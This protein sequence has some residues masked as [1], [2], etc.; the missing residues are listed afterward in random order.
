M[1]V[2]VTGAAGF[3]G[4]PLVE[5]LLS[6]GHKV[7]A[8]AR[9]PVTRKFA[10]YANLRWIKKDLA[11]DELTA[12]ELSDVETIF[13]LAGTKE[14]GESQ[15]ETV[16]LRANEE[17]TLKI[18]LASAKSV[19]KIIFASTQMVYG[20]PGNLSVA[21]DFPLLGMESSAYGCS[22][23]NAE[24]W[25]RCLQKQHGGFFISLRFCGFVEGGGNIDYIID[26]ALRNEPV[27]LLSKGEVCRDYLSLENGVDAF[28]A[29]S[30][31]VSKNGFEVF[32]IGS[33]QIISTHEMTRFICAELESK[34]EIILLDRKAPRDNF[35]FNIHK[36]RQFLKFEPHSLRKSICSYAHHKKS[37]FKLGITDA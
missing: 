6:Q 3:L 20:D 25:L 23:V 14:L 33:G 28:I 4:T 7:V 26:R 29:A 24:N 34:S 15:D 37:I 16:F 30:N 13:H 5:R 32:N 18:L 21:E 31:Y 12:E 35:V 17:A 36:A 2:L 1:A 9:G 11:V 27:E 19:K 22:K 10:G 8:V